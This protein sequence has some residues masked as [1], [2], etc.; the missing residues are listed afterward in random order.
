MF[1]SGFTKIL[2][3]I[4]LLPEQFLEIHGCSNGKLAEGLQPF[5]GL[6]VDICMKL[7]L[8]AAGKNRATP[9]PPPP[10]PHDE[11]CFDVIYAVNSFLVSGLCLLFAVRF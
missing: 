7:I 9:P 2:V 3:L 4:M 6:A 11:D 10:P 5:N 1:C 8:S